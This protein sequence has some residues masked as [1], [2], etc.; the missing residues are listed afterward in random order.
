MIFNVGLVYK[1][2]PVLTLGINIGS[3][4]LSNDAI[5][6]WL[7]VSVDHHPL[8]NITELTK[9]TL[10]M[11]LHTSFALGLAPLAVPIP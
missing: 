1:S 7:N 11:S 9:N 6:I 5:S 8:G 3:K 10:V 2:V 4:V